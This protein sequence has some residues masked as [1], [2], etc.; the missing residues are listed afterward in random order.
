[1]DVVIRNVTL[2]RKHPLNTG[3][4]VD[5]GVKEGIFSMIQPSIPERGKLEIDGK[6]NLFSPP[7]IDPHLHLDAVLTV[8]DPRYNS[9]GTLLEGIQIWSERK[10]GLTKDDI[11]KRALEA[12]SWMAAQ[13]VLHIRTHADSSDPSLTTVRALTELRDELAGT[14]DIQVVAFPQDGIYTHAGGERLMREAVSLG[15]DV[16]GGIPHNELTREDGIKDVEFAYSLAEE[17]GL[18]IDIHCDETDDDQSRFVETM[19]ALSVKNGM[20]G[21]AAASHVTAMHSYNNA[22]AFKLMGLLNR[23]KMNIIVNPFDNSIL[24]ARGD[25]YPKRRGIARVD[26]LIAAGVNV[27][28]GHD[29]IMD[30]WY[31]LGRGNMLEAANLLLHLAQLSGYEQIFDVFETITNRSARTLGIEHRYGIEEGKPADGIILDCGNEFEA[32]RKIPVCRFVLRGGTVIARTE[33]SVST[34]FLKG[35]EKIVDFTAPSA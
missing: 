16:I 12:V 11:K 31:P 25:S 32:L 23:A 22:Y 30:P 15:V 35:K 7:F 33:P 9:S 6:G 28:T 26:E 20:E 17:H 27:C 24:Q 21:T 2:P 8:G 4:P 10:Q 14:V 3:N 18:L 1:M 34:V 13:G 19:A 29:S 5:I